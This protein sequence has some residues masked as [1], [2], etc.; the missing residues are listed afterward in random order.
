MS[1]LE[2][3]VLL[4]KYH[5]LLLAAIERVELSLPSELEHHQRDF[6]GNE[7]ISFP[8]MSPLYSLADT[9][10]TDVEVLE[11]GGRSERK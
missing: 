1:H 3:S 2:L 5:A 4:D 7:T 6:L 9:L 10:A 11:I 8:V